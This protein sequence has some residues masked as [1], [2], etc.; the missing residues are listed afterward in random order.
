MDDAKIEACARAAHKVNNAYC[1]AVGDAPAPDW[2]DMTNAQRAGVIQGA[3]HA[4]RGGTLAESHALWMASRLAEGWT[5]GPV[6]SFT[7][8]TSPC[9]VPY[10]DLPL[11]QRVKDALFQ[12]VV[13]AT[14]ETMV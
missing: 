2:E 11:V 9:L 5:L 13:R 8:K 10:D 12:A 4:L 3:A 7:A 14:A 6:K 1:L